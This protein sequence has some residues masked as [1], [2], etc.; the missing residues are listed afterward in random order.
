MKR[1]FKSKF[2]SV[3]VEKN[4]WWPGARGLL[5]TGTISSASPIQIK[6]RATWGEGLLGTGFLGDWVPGGQGSWRTGF[7]GSWI[8]GFLGS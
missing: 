1:V 8:P 5:P 3:P 6:A 7:L 2:L 4:G